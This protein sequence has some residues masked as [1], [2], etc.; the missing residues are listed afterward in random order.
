[1]QRPPMDQPK[2]QKAPAR[3][4]T[5]R[6]RRLDAEEGN[7][8]PDFFLPDLCRV[9]AVLLIVLGAELMTLLFTLIHSGP[10]R[11]DWD[12]LALSSLFT[13]WV[14]LSCAG[15]LC[16][17][18]PRLARMPLRRGA[19]ICYLLVLGVTL[20]FALG[21]DR[22]FSL[23]TAQRYAPDWRFVLHCLLI[24]AI[25]TGI[26]LRY[27]Y[28]HHRWQLQQQAE[29]QARLQALQARIRPHFLFNSMNTIASL[30]AVDPERAEDA[31]LDLAEVF[32]ATLNQNHPL[33]PLSQ[34][35]ELCAR[36]LRIEQL[37]LGERLTIE[38]KVEPETG[39]VLVPPISLQPLVENAVYH[40]V[41]PLPEGGTVLIE[42]YRRKDFLYVLVS[43]PCPTAERGLS[44]ATENSQHQGNRMALDNIRSR[45]EA[46]F[47]EQAVLKSSVQ[48][49]TYTVTLRFPVKPGRDR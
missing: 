7:E 15:L 46:L 35:L 30:I 40:G 28:L 37:R 17:L 34:E 29:L 21:A 13:Q 20:L 43:N 10:N 23:E 1:M 2:P 24:S 6:Q 27:F 44:A 49:Q 14:V 38:W 19:T 36:Y 45:L 31:V 33:V 4:P 42:S 32:R 41:Q 5:A 22:F 11:F 47:G 48:Q 3:T 9:Q 18:R 12:Y 16:R 39:S 25:V 26:G 8:A